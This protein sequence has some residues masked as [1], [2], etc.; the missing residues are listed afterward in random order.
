[1]EE[2]ML[3]RKFLLNFLMFKIS[4]MYKILGRAARDLLQN[5]LQF[6]LGD[7]FNVNQA[8]NHHYFNGYQNLRYLQ[9]PEDGFD[10]TVE[11]QNLTMV[12]WKGKK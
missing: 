12:E 4:V 10:P 11:Y 6:N 8:L 1:L 7:R 9:G 3:L 2:K 5:L